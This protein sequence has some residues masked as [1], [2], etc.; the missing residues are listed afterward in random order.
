[1]IIKNI[2]TIFV[3][4]FMF[5]QIETNDGITGLGESGA[6]GHLE[7]SA[8]AVETF[9]RYLI[10]KDPLRIE[11]HQQYLYRNSH[12][13]G[14]A[15]MGAISA[16]DIALWDIAGKFYNAPCYQLLGGKCRDWARVYYHV[17][18]STHDE[19]IKG[20][21]EA[22]RLGFTA[23]G[24]LSPFLPDSF[25]MTHSM[26]M[27]DASD[28]IGEYREAVGDDVDLCIEIHRELK[29]AQAIVLGN[30]IE[31]YRPMFFEDP[32]PPDDL[33]AMSRVARKINIPIATGERLL[34]VQEFMML[35]RR[36]AAEY[37]RPDVCTVGGLT[38]A[39][40]IAAVAEANYVGVIPHNPLSRVSTASCIQLAACIPNFV[41]QEYPTYE[42]TPIKEVV[43]TSLTLKNGHIKIPDEPGIGAELN[44]DLLEKFPYTPRTPTTLLKKDG[45]IIDC[46]TVKHRKA[47]DKEEHARA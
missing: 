42:T 11:H 15:I 22:K 28:R 26:M 46:Y 3:D 47:E 27:K 4:R 23:V 44:I 29:P 12:F 41:I 30:L 43:K 7:A 38:G 18:Y 13:R 16:I 24:H 8:G 40:K 32:V 37:I 33:D 10:G 34:T 36:D 39:K 20:C 35:L 19:L 14:S 45:S 21:K 1:M 31:K 6:W 2:K 17:I 25:D 5:I 9:K